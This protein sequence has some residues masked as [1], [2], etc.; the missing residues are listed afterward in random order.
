M[1]NILHAKLEHQLAPPQVMKNAVMTKQANERGCKQ[2]KVFNYF[3]NNCIQNVVV[4]T[5]PAPFVC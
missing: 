4:L 2:M 1:D 3:V 5:P